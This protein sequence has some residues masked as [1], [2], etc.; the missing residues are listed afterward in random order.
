MSLS[1]SNSK[2]PIP[3][4]D[5]KPAKPEKPRGPSR[6]PRKD[7]RAARK[8]NDFRGLLHLLQ[9]VLDL[10]RETAQA[11]A[12]RLGVSPY[13]ALVDEFGE[14]EDTQPGARRKS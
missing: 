11:K 10:T 3:P 4:T 8:D 6:G 1:K 12:P 13:D 2:P 7:S 14:E 5:G 9:Q